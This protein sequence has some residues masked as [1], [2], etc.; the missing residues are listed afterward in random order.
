VP[1]SQLLPLSN[2]RK[3]QIVQAENIDKTTTPLRFGKPSPSPFLH[4]CF[5]WYR[6]CF[7]SGSLLIFV[8]VPVERLYTLASVGRFWIVADF[9]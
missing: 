1:F 7:T 5:P 8:E 2:A 6:F 4:F 3:N 9:C